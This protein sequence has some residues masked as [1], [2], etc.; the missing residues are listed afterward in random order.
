MNMKGG[1]L[2]D[3]Y[4]FLYARGL[5]VQFKSGELPKLWQMQYPQLF[6][7]KDLSLTRAGSNYS[8]FEWMGAILLYHATGYL[9]YH[10][11][12]CENHPEK[13][14]LFCRLVDPRFKRKTKQDSRGSPDLFVVAPDHSE[15]FF[16]EAKGPGDKIGPRQRTFARYIL[17]RTGRKVTV[18]NF[19]PVD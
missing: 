5:R 1:Q 18:L 16:C 13:H 15:Y 7:K 9:S 17:R 14:A 6:N 19:I 11:W 3:N 2:F 4:Q 8:F 10:K 12:D